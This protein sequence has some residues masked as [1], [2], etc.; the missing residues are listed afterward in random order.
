MGISIALRAPRNTKIECST[1]TPELINILGR[2]D[3][4][5]AREG[6]NPR[7]QGFKIHRFDRYPLVGD[8]PPVTW[9]YYAQ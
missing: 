4:V 9:R 5:A 7:T 6:P 8:T 3:E 2:A 1:R